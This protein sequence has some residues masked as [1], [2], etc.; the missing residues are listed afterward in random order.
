M[1][2]SQ[3][4]I[5][6]TKIK[7]TID[8]SDNEIKAAKNMVVKKLSKSVKVPGFRAGK[9]PNHLIEKNIEAN[10]L[11]SEVIEELINRLY[12]EAAKQLN[13]RIVSQ[14]QLAVTKFVPF[15][16]LQFTAE[17]DYVGEVKLAD[18][19]KIKI[20]APAVNVTA[21]DVNEVITNLAARSA[22]KKAVDRKAKDKDEVVIDFAGYEIG[23][24]DILPGTDGK[25]YPLTIG[26]NSFIPGFEQELIG[27]KKDDSKSFDITFPKNYGA[28]NMQG[29][30]VTFK[31]TVKTVNEQV[32]PKIDD[33][34]ASTV[35]P[36]KALSELKAD[37]KKQLITEKKRESQQQHENDILEEISQK[38][39]IALP[40]S[41][42]NEELDRMEAEEKRN[43]IY[44]GQTWQEHL[45]EEGL[46]EEQHRENKRSAAESR[47]KIGIILGEI[48]EAE[49]IKVTEAEFEQR[50]QDLRK[51]YQDPAMQAELDKPENQRDIMSRMLTEKTLDKLRSYAV[52]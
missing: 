50:M 51:Q 41:L 33:K 4:K 21:A 15:S 7:I 35:G 19:K 18:Y 28:K 37:I 48:A 11:Q 29:K 6:P 12:P 49:K 23:G 5:N 17:V 31:V 9:A 34:F 14:P 8:A 39:Q 2:V 27:L 43:I 13:L 40:D 22:E 24:K 20:Y 42:I 44:R 26:S 25:D 32:L 3:E 1:Q 10:I 52:K 45:D 36:F 47:V 38:S 46:T 16:D 30:K